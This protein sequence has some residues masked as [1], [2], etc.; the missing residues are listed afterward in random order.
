MLPSEDGLHKK[1]GLRESDIAA[2]RAL[3][4]A[5]RQHDGV[6]V[7]INWDTLAARGNCRTSDFLYAS[8]GRWVGYL[9]LFQYSSAEV[10]VSGMV[11]PGY[12]R[13]GIF[14]QLWAMAVA[15][16]DLRAAQRILLICDHASESGRGFAQHINAKVA[17]SEY[18]MRLDPSR[19]AAPASGAP[20]LRLRPAG[21]ADVREIAEQNALYF[22]G[23]VEEQVEMLRDMLGKADSVTYAAWLDGRIVGKVDLRSDAEEGWIYGLGI[24]PEHRGRGLGRQLLT[25]SV[26]LLQERRPAAILLEVE[27]RNERALSLYQSV[28]FVQER[29]Y[30]YWEYRL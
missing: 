16:C 12:R 3:V 5:C 4:D 26:A 11:H 23:E 7:R 29:V 1:Y 24:R 8:D 20:R 10:E 22:G 17:F 30:D 9:G 19:A 28:G 27:A 6:Q 14:A 21:L 13:Q 25:R 18:R 15:Q 2:I